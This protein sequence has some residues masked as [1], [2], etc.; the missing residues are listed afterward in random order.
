MLCRL[1]E[2]IVFSNVTSLELLPIVALVLYLFYRQT[3]DFIDVAKKVFREE[4]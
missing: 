4:A 1:V 3:K 2:K